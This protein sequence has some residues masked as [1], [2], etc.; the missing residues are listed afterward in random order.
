LRVGDRRLRSSG[1]VLTRETAH[2]R[3]DGERAQQAEASD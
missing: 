1:I 2:V 3:G